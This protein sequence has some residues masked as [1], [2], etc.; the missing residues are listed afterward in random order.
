MYYTGAGMNPA[1]SF[2]PAVLVRNFIN[3]WVSMDLA[4]D[5]IQSN[6][7][8]KKDISKENLSIE[9]S[10]IAQNLLSE[11]LQ[12]KS[13]AQNLKGAVYNFSSSLVPAK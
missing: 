10:I 7:Q 13:L 4:D 8:V 1:R 12:P 11:N 9:L 5:F 2:A 3:H 6:L